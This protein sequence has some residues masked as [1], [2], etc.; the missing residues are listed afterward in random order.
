MKKT[1]IVMMAMIMVFAFAACGSSNDSGDNGN[2]E[3][4]QTTRVEDQNPVSEYEGM[5]SCD[6]ALINIGPDGKDGVKAVVTWGSSASE[7]S[8][9]VMSGTFD[10]DDLVFEYHDCVKTDYV[11]DEDGE[12]ESEEEVYKG[13]HGF[14]KFKD[15]DKVTLTWQDDQEHAA[16]DM[17]FKIEKK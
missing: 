15:G 6:R 9:W 3:E 13:G 17:V 1:L 14:M 12:K 2:S 10:E 16:D 4:T 8:E 7:H 5:Y 11:Y